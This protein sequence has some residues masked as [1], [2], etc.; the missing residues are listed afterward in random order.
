MWIGLLD[1]TAERHEVHVINNCASEHSLVFSPVLTRIHPSSRSDTMIFG[2]SATS[3]FAQMKWLIYCYITGAVCFDNF[4]AWPHTI[5]LLGGWRRFSLHFSKIVVEKNTLLARLIIY[6]FDL[7]HNWCGE[8][9][10]WLLSNTLI[11]FEIRS[12]KVPLQAFYMK[13]C[14]AAWELL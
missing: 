9:F 6:L 14:K 1:Q 11:I 13:N 3:L 2:P 10:P 5:Y 4:L 7:F 8:L 12:Y